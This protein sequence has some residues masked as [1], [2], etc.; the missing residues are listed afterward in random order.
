MEGVDFLNSRLKKKITIM[1]WLLVFFMIIVLNLHRIRFALD[2]YNIYSQEKKTNIVSE[3]NETEDKVEIY[4]PLTSIIEKDIETE[5]DNDNDSL[6]DEE[7]VIAQ[8]VVDKDTEA[9]NWPNPKPVEQPDNTKPYVSIIKEYNEKLESL[10][11]SFESKLDNLISQGI[12]EYQSRTMSTA[13]LSSK[14]L[15]AGTSLERT[16]DSEFNTLVKEMEKE[17]KSNNHDV[18]VI[19]EIREYYNSFKNEMKQEIIG[20]GLK[21]LR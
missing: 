7:P 11:G 8:P 3:N 5:N 20:R 9:D 21:H 18:K 6:I 15:S 10:R 17:L 16:S 2:M 13:K 19:K 12:A 1:L 14:Y 4:N